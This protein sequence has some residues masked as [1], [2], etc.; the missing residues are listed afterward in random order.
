MA[1]TASGT[2]TRAPAA[3]SAPAPAPAKAPGKALN[4]ASKAR[5]TKRF[6]RKATENWS[7]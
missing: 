6:V 5:K 4:D 3:I 2:T 7:E 1:A